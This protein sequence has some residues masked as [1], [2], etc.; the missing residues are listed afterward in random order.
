MPCRADFLAP[1]T[2]FL[3]SHQLNDVLPMEK[4]PYYS[5]KHIRSQRMRHQNIRN[6]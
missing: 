1:Q 6:K 5:G 2:A 3:A 4:H